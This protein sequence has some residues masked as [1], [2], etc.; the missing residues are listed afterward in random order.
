M[1]LYKSENFVLTVKVTL[2]MIILMICSCGYIIK[3]GGYVLYY[4]FSSVNN[5]EIINN[6]YTGVELKKFLLLADEI[7]KYAYDSIGLTHVKSYTRYVDID[8]TYL[9]DVVSGCE[10][11]SFQKYMWKFPFVGSMPYKGFF[12]RKDAEEEAAKIEAKGYDVVI[13]MVDAFS[14]LGILTDP[15]YSYMR[16]YSEYALANLLI[17]ELT[18]GTIYLKNQSQFN[19]QTATFIGDQGAINFI[20]H[21]YGDTSAVYKDIFIMKKDY[22]VYIELLRGLYRELDTVYRNEKI[23][24]T[25]KLRKKDEIIQG[26]REKIIKGYGTYFQTDRFRSID[27]IKINNAYISARMTYNQNLY[28]FEEL[29]RK[30]Q[31]SLSAVVEYLKKCRKIKCRN[32]EELIRQECGLQIVN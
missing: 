6:P 18:H 4:N 3:Q 21:K 12:E 2:V 30:K 25:E 22:E 8:K 29:Y 26:F 17:H 28:L 10:Q 1:H 23:A 14:S 24:R 32:A 9:V 20:R 11:A 16:K 13:G 19:E 5:A 15:L 31:N 27:K 7:R